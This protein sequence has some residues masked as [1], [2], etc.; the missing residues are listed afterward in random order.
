MVSLDD[1]FIALVR[2]LQ[3]STHGGTARWASSCRSLN[4]PWCALS[5]RTTITLWKMILWGSSL[6]PSRAS[7]QVTVKNLPTW[8][9][10][11]KS[12]LWHVFVMR[13]SLSPLRLSTCSPTEGRWFQSV[14]SYSLHPFKSE[15]QRNSR[16]KCVR[17]HGRLQ[18]QSVKWV[19]T[20]W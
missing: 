4:W 8:Q 6:C 9:S 13:D 1:V 17:A 11:V 5:W 18:T 3:A 16:Q 7:A 10:R 12:A 20:R 14:P 19:W 15:P 2:P